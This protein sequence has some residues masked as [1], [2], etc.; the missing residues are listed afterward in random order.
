MTITTELVVFMLTVAGVAGGIW[1][2]IERM[3]QSARS[4]AIAAAD[5]AGIA[6][7]A[8]STKAEMIQAALTARPYGRDL[9][10]QVR[11]ARA[12]R[13]GRRERE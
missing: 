13:A 5:K 12:G 2:R 10:Q 7:L 4:D 1:I 6:A 11:P 8:S 3:I 9:C